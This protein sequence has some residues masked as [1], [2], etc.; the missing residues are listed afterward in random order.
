MQYLQ[1][2]PHWNSKSWNHN[3]LKPA[4]FFPVYLFKMDNAYQTKMVSARSFH[5]V[6]L[7][8]PLAFTACLK[9]ELAPFYLFSK[10]LEVIYDLERLASL[11]KPLRAA[12][13][14]KNTKVLATSTCL[15]NVWAF[16]CRW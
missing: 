12:G 14:F 8:A 10:R 4:T 1:V 7:V 16:Q 13:F 3:L 2:G 11:H 9:G 6:D 5:M 15:R